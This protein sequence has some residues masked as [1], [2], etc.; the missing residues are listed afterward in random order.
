M[1]APIK[2]AAEFDKLFAEAE[3]ME[4]PKVYRL[5][6]LLSIRLGLRPMEIAGLERSWFRDDTLRIPLGHSKRKSGRSVPVSGEILEAL[7]DLMQD[8]RGRV[9]RNSRGKPFTANGISEALRRLYKRAGVTGSCYS[10]RRT[11]A[12]NLVDEGVS[13]AVVQQVLGHGNLSTTAS[14]IGVTEGMMRRA[15]F[16]S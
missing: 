8:E 12:T 10:G 3:R 11:L 6:L 13:L 15:M 7:S 5:M 16:G 4:R 9:F 1:K 14:Y 2:E